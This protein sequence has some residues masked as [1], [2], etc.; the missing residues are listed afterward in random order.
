[1]NYTS[2]GSFKQIKFTASNSLSSMSHSVDV[3]FDDLPDEGGIAWYWV[4]L[5]VVLVLIVVAVAFG[6]FKRMKAKKDKKVSLVTE[7]EED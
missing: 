6:Y 7:G 5:I 3:N 1:M 4:V 2:P